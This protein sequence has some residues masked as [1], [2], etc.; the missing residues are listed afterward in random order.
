MWPNTA[1]DQK[2][3]G[4]WGGGIPGPLGEQIPEGFLLVRKG[5]PPPCGIFLRW[6]CE[7]PAERDGTDASV[8]VL[9]VAGRDN[10]R[11]ALNTATTTLLKGL[12]A[13]G[14]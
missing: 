1:P 7:V 12:A 11:E 4:S 6:L 2:D 5:E 14:R 10:W 9:P 13:D 8:T 3:L